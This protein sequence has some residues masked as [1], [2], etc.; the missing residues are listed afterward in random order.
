MGSVAARTFPVGSLVEPLAVGGLLGRRAWLGSL[1][2]LHHGDA[3]WV[4]RRRERA[5]LH[6]RPLLVHDVSGV[7]DELAGED[8]SYV[9]REK[10]CCFELLVDDLRLGFRAAARRVETLESQE[11]HE[12]D[13]HRK[14]GCNHTEDPRGTVAVL[15]IAA[16]RCA[17]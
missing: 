4:P 9:R 5:G 14:A 10:L 17:A 8:A 2:L 16:G 7:A 15:E 13:Q 12:A 11:D 1:Q 3:P 6:P